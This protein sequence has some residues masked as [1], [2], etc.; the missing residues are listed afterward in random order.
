MV[1]GFRDPQTANLIPPQASSLPVEITRSA[2]LQ[3]LDAMNWFELITPLQINA[4]H[5]RSHRDV[6]YVRNVVEFKFNV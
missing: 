2:D 5:Y 6:R 1:W 4:S 3:K